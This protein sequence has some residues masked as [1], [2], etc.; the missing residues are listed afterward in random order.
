MDEYCF[1]KDYVDLKNVFLALLQDCPVAHCHFGDFRI[2][3]KQN[4]SFVIGMLIAMHISEISSEIEKK[5]VFSG[6]RKAWA[7][8]PHPYKEKV[9]ST[10]P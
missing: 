3:G 9:S 7:T 1:D 10:L 2:E 8:N 5:N 4:T 6:L